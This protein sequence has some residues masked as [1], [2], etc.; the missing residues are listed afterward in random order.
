MTELKRTYNI[1]LRKAYINKPIYKKTN[2]AVRALKAFVTKHMKATEVKIGQHLNEEIWARGDCKPPHHVLVDCVKNDEGIVLVEM[3]GKS[4]KESVKPDKKSEEPQ[5]LQD[6]IQNK[7]GKDKPAKDTDKT[8]EDDKKETKE[9]TD[10]TKETENKEKTPVK[11][12]VKKVVK[13][14]VVKKTE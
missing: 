7:L 11:K 4:Y 9:T 5:T 10:K 13:K 1:P 6:K 2:T 14:K 3:A 12:V 8:K